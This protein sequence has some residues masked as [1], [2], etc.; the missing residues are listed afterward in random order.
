[1]FPVHPPYSC[2]AALLGDF[3]GFVHF[4]YKDITVR[5]MFPYVRS[6]RSLRLSTFFPFLSI[7]HLFAKKGCNYLGW[8]HAT[9]HTFGQN[10][11]ADHSV[12][13][14]RSRR[15]VVL[16]NPEKRAFHHQPL[17]ERSNLRSKDQSIKVNISVD[18]RCRTKS[19]RA[20]SAENSE[21][22]PP[23]NP[24]ACPAVTD[25]QWQQP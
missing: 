9:G 19:T 13:F 18:P 15:S 16:F 14:S 20:R 25:S 5:S 22:K 7:G 6:M 4:S 23:S 21:P 10:L 3:S 11:R 2:E 12:R 24:R 17:M 1:M 8:E